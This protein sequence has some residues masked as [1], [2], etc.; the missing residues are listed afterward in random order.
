MLT[1][2]K[3]VEQIS[4]MLDLDLLKV[5]KVMANLVNKQLVIKDKEGYAL[6]ALGKKR[7]TIL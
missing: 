5:E 2:P 6:S 1:T 3:N 4:Q 7:V